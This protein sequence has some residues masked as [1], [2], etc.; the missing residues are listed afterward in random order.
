[1]ASGID[2]YNKYQNVTDWAAVRGAGY[3]FCYVKVSDGLTARSTSGYGPGGRAGG[4]AMGA[5]HYAQPGDP[6][7]QAELLISQ[8]TAS[9]CTDLGPALDLEDPFVPG[10]TAA[11]FA[12]A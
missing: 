10:A 5:Y 6:V 4:L 8:A 11:N 3:T 2:V 9:G 12:I 1:M 7:A